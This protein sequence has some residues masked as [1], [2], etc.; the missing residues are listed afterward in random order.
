MNQEANN[1][2]KATKNKSENV[3]DDGNIPPIDLPEGY[4]Q[5]KS[6]KE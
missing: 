1:T 5:D 4:T 6:D 3:Y 2:T